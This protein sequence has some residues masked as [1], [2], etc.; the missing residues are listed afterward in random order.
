[1]TI[2]HDDEPIM[3]EDRICSQ[4]LRV[5]NAV[6]HPDVS[7]QSAE[8]METIFN[9]INDKIE[10]DSVLHLRNERKHAFRH[11]LQVACVL[12]FLLASIG[13]AYY[14]GRSSGND[15]LVQSYVETVAP[16]GVSTKLTLADGTTVTLN[17]GSKLTYPALFTANERAVTLSGEGFFEVTKD[18]NRPFVVRSQNLSVKV[19]GTKFG[20]KSYP[21]DPHTAVTLKEGSVQ[22][23]PQNKPEQAG[24][25]LKPGQQ[26]VLDNQTGEFQ[27]RNVNTDEY[28]SWKEGILYFRDNTLDEITRVLERKFNVDIH[29]VSDEIRY[30]RYFAHFGNGENVEQVLK[31]LSLK[32]PWKYEYRN[33]TIEIKKK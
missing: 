5:L 7:R 1:M 23:T 3:T 10:V 19:L 11:F 25:I 13:T 26:L 24:I 31:L 16:L 17:S 14:A 21:D 20:F 29:I 18:V 32:R 8:S 30:D 22:A 6:K 33:G 12:L 15:V 27:C 9:R 2:H 28:I 4:V